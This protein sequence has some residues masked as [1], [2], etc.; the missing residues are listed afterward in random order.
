MPSSR[1]RSHFASSVASF[2]VAVGLVAC[3]SAPN[4][5]GAAAGKILLNGDVHSNIYGFD[6]GSGATTKI[7]AGA[8]P[9]RT[10]E[11][12]IL[13]VNT[14]T[15]DLGEYSA[16]GTQFRVIVKANDQQ[17]FDQ[18][19]DDHFQNPQLSPDGKYVV[20]E[21]QLGYTFDIYVV[22]RGSGQLLA[23]VNPPQVGV[24]YVRPT[25]TPDNRLV[26][27]GGTRNSGLY[28]SDA[29]WTHFTRFDQNLAAP[30]QPAVSPDGKTVAFV[31]NGHVFTVVIDGTGVT[32]VTQSSGQESWP[33]WSPDG[34]QL[35]LYTDTS[36]QVVAFGG[37]G[38]P[39]DLKTLND[40]FVVFTATHSGQMSWR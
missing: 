39:L 35:L 2:T 30:D 9:F 19:Y 11:G 29:T 33:T 20:Y 40:N 27:A 36:I 28:L 24:G 14:N 12:T 37:A 18:T 10:P 34:A 17:P 8:D 3:S 13:C 25:W 23:G 7:V 16:D 4:E 22:D 6:L 21:G 15:Q 5:K 31:M 32:Q 38:T 26:V 1:L